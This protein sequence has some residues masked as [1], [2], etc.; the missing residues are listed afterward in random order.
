[1]SLTAGEIRRLHTSFGRVDEIVERR[2]TIYRLTLELA[3]ARDG[4][5]SDDLL[6][7]A[8]VDNPAVRAHLA[9]VLAGTHDLD[10][11]QVRPLDEPAVAYDVAGSSL[12]LTTGVET[13]RSLRGA[14]E[15]LGADLDEPGFADRADALVLAGSAEFDAVE[16]VIVEGVELAADVAPE[17]VDD[18]V[19]HVALLAV[20]R[21]DA[22]GRLGSASVRE[23][24][25]LVLLPEPRTPLEVAEA[26]VH[27]GAHQKFFDLAMTGDLLAAPP[28]ERFSPPWS[29]D[30][31]S[32]PF[33]QSVAAFHAYCCLSALADCVPGD[34]ALHDYSLLPSAQ[35]RAKVIG[36]WLAGYGAHLGLDGQAFVGGLRR[37]AVTIVPQSSKIAEVVAEMDGSSEQIAW[38]RCGDRALVLQLTRPAA[39]F[40]MPAGAVGAGER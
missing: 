27:E 2:R 8:V 18:L 29:G 14:L 16:R 33:E 21:A 5:A 20:L 31:A 38:R 10:L 39:L 13:A 3:C 37:D 26:L 22:A 35:G 6:D 17:L 15:R 32:W 36:D 24:P 12:R 9:G 34:L 40:W 1:M 4:V 25:G 28:V 7:L 23:F 11:R 19:P 30:G